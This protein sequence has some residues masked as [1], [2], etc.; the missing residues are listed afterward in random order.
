L[1]LFKIEKGLAA[2]LATKRPN[3]TEGYCY[4]TTDD[5]KFY[6]DTATANGTSK[7][8]VL[9]AGAADKLNVGTIGSEIKP[10]YFK[11]GAPVAIEGLA[12]KEYVDSV[13]GGGDNSDKL[14]KNGDTMLGELTLQDSLILTKDV[15]Y[16]ED[17]PSDAVDG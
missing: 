9:N 5:G 14:S 13:A 6:I 2:D 1:A 12:T 4:V 10:I 8:I 15:H 17:F 11:D 3:T 7:R 16:G